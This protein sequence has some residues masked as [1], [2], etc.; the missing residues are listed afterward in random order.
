M[1]VPTNWR[2]YRIAIRIMRLKEELRM[3]DYMI[4]RYCRSANL[5]R[6]EGLSN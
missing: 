1:E 4:G 2:A 6:R 3:E 5:Y